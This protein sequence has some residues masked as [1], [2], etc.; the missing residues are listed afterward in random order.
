MRR[1]GPCTARDR[2][3]QRVT[4]DC[5]LPDDGQR[6]AKVFADTTA[7]AFARGFEAVLGPAHPRSAQARREADQGRN[8]VFTL[9]VWPGERGGRYAQWEGLPAG[10]VWYF[11]RWGGGFRLFPRDDARTWSKAAATRSA[12]RR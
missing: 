12:V 9:Y 5:T 10:S 1:G 7:E 6:L 2:V 4:E 11:G 3:A 8:A